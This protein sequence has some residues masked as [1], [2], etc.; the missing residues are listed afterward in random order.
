[1]TGAA[2]AALVWI[3]L[4]LLAAVIV[5]HASYTADMSAF[6]PRRASAAQRL[7]VEQL[8]AGPAAH[9]VIAAI[10]GADATTRAQVSAALAARLRSD[11]AFIS[12]NNGDAAQLERDQAFLFEHRYLL[13]PQVNAERFSAGGLHTAIGD[14][15]DALTSP[16]GLLLKPLFTR[17]PT[18]EMRVIIDSLTAGRMPHTSGGVWTSADGARALLVAQTRAA[19]SDTDGQQAALVALRRAFAA[20]LAQLPPARR[21]SLT[22]AVS[23]P[24]VFAVAARAT[25]EQQVLRLST[26]S[27]LLI[28][29]LLLA[30]YRSP[31]ALALTFVPVASGAL[32]GVA[33]VALAFP[34]VHGITLGFGVTLIGEAVDYS[35]YLLVQNPPDF[36]RTV[37]PTIRLGMLTS[38]CGFA[39]LLPSAFPGLA[40]LGLYS[41]AGLIAA[42]LVTRCVL[43]QWLPRRGALRDLSG[44]GA[45]L[46][47]LLARLRPLRRALLLVP[48]LAGAVLYLH[49]GALWSH[50]L[51][52]LSPI[53]AAD[54]ALDE[55]LRADAGAPDVRFMVVVPAT[56]P[57]RALAAAALVG[58]QLEP[59]VDA[60]LIGG[61]ESPARYLPALA[62]QRA[63][64]AS[65]PPPGELRERLTEAL[66]GLPLAP[67]RLEPFVREVQQARDAP[68]LTRAA[69]D[70]TSFA[71]GVDTLLVRSGAGWAALLPVAGVGFGELSPAAVTAVRA[72]LAAAGVPA[73]LLDIKGEADRLYAGYL[74]QAVQ[75]A[76]AGLGAIVLLLLLALRSARRVANVVAPLIL[77]VLAVAALLTATGHALGIL[78]VVGMLL[79][80]AVGSNYALFFDRTHHPSPAPSPYLTL[81]SLLVANV[82]TVTAFG[83][84][85][86]SSVPVLADLGSTVAP[87]A[88]L[89]LLF[90]ALLAPPP[91]A[92]AGA[93]ALQSA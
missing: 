86:F 43:P 69:L 91:R 73:Q 68:L 65:L 31:R 78:H 19:G 64:Q 20:A 63:R 23:G 88:L 60:G 53:P 66:T 45:L 79:I 59:L 27:A 25:I 52:A 61:F 3:V 13:S 50:E 47:G 17:D 40:Q 7:L 34:V 48:L 6:L 54:Q 81:A 10:E 85:A 67:A 71:H 93:A 76:L 8:R 74:L 46:A 29:L 24:P 4:V 37:W 36:A 5:A 9:L 2:R 83:V 33:A 51:T 32:A 70:G 1:M 11:A 90:A 84:L 82:A 42:A 28:A 44:L 62:V 89:A 55:R 39:A 57:E 49:R 21:D 75:L 22:L 16:E 18:G 77:A 41:I 35:I 14:S 12:V 30:L 38:I 72:A 56:T 58:A 92:A 87:G 26:L 15:L 80:V